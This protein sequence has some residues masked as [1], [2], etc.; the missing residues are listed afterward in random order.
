MKEFP[1][2]LVS[3]ASGSREILSSGQKD[4]CSSDVENNGFRICLKSNMLEIKFDWNQEVYTIDSLPVDN[5]WNH[6]IIRWSQSQGLSASKHGSTSLTSSSTSSNTYQAR[7]STIKLGHNPES[8][9]FIQ[10]QSL[11]IWKF[12]LSQEEID[13][14]YG[15]GS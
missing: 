8:N 6:F 2:C 4:S 3:G 11:K 7:G 5:G 15:T 13:A 9:D 12:V 10:I 14:L 1:F